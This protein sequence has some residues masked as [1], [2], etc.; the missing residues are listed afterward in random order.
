MKILTIF[1]VIFSAA[2]NVEGERLPIY[3]TN[4]MMALAEKFAVI[5]VDTIDD[6][7]ERKSVLKQ[8]K[9]SGKEIIKITEAQ[10]CQFAGN[11]LQVK[12]ADDEKFTV[13]S[14]RAYNS[15]TQDQI[16]AIERHSKIISSDLNI[17][18][19]CGGGSARCMMAEVFLP[20]A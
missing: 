8:L 18:E 16:N 2:Q 13:M 20:K 17:I 19:T 10:M 9:K 1:P 5:C 6:K 4:V 7:E 12:G 15:L 14:L 11:M 3:H